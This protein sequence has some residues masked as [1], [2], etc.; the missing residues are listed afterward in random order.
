MFTTRKTLKFLRQ[1]SKMTLKRP[2]EDD[3]LLIQ[4]QSKMRPAKSAAHIISSNT[5]PESS[6][7]TIRPLQVPILCCN[8][9]GAVIPYRYTPSP[10]LPSAPHHSGMACC[11]G[12]LR[13]NYVNEPSP[14]WLRVWMGV[15]RPSQGLC[16]LL[17]VG[18]VTGH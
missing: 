5:H 18:L 3:I 17:P 15:T 11:H 13:T 14:D 7:K 16:C 2:S 9:E 12:M 1:T 4:A 6:C 8:A 10:T